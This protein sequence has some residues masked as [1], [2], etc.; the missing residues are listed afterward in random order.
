MKVPTVTQQLFQ[1]N[2]LFFFA[3]DLINL[4]SCFNDKLEITIYQCLTNHSPSSIKAIV[5]KILTCKISPLLA[6]L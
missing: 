3:I 2:Y 6:T 1:S 4:S 5:P